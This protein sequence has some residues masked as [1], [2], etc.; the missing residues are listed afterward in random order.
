MAKTDGRLA[1][2]AR[3]HRGRTRPRT[4]ARRRRGAVCRRRAARAGAPRPGA[5][6]RRARA[7]RSALRLGR[8]PGPGRHPA[9]QPTLPSRNPHERSP[10]RPTARPFAAR[11]SHRAGAAAAGAGLLRHRAVDRRHLE[12][13][14]NLHP[15]LH[16]RADQPVAGLAA[17]RHLAPAAGHA[18]LAGPAAAARLRLRLAAG[19][20]RRRP[21]RQAIRLRRHAAADR[22]GDARHAHRPHHRL[23]PA[24][25]AVRGA[26]RRD[27]HP[28]PDRRHR[29]LHHPCAARDRHSGPAR[30]QHLQH[31]DRQLVGGRSLQR[32]A[33]PDRLDHAGHPVR[34]PDLPLD[35]AAR[36]VRA[37][38]DHRADLRQQRPRLHDRHDGP[39]ERHDAWRSAST[40]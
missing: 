35:A 24:V 33:L 32:P 21:D 3:R 34:L 18:V 11:R 15:R 37:A 12:P 9:R 36:A 25:P 22:A 19:R 20:P 5:R 14:R 30:R 2:G 26:V 39:P 17:P 23:R 38:V 1:A 27:L 10:S 13:L 8:Q 40:T 29:Q 7:R 31:P 16:H 28:A 6:R 4:G